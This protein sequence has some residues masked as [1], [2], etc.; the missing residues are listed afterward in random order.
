MAFE[1]F[2]AGREKTS[3][4]F[5]EWKEQLLAAPW[6]EDVRWRVGQVIYVF[7]RFCKR[8]H[9]PASVESA[10]AFV[11]SEA[12]QRDPWIRPAL[13]WLCT[14]G[15]VVDKAWLAG[16]RRDGT[17]GTDAA[18]GTDSAG[19][20]RV[21]NG[22]G[23]GGSGGRGVRPMEEL[24]GGAWESARPVVPAR[25]E[26]GVMGAGDGTDGADN[27]GAGTAG[28]ARGGEK[29]RVGAAGAED[30]TDSRGAG[31]G[32]A[33]GGRRDGIVR[34][35][36][37]GMGNGTKGTDG[38]YGTDSGGAG[39]A[40]EARG[41]VGGA[42]A[43][44]KNGTHETE[45]TDGTDRGEA[46]VMRGG[47]DGQDGTDSE[48]REGAVAGAEGAGG[49]RSSTPSR[50]AE[51]LGGPDWERALVTAL[52]RKGMLW[53]TEQTYR[54]WARRFAEFIRPRSPFAAGGEEVADFLTAMAVEFRA[55]PATQRQA[56]NA[57]VF[58][59]QEGL[60]REV[61]ELDFRRSAARKRVPTVL[62]RA[63]CT[64][65]FEAITGSNR[66]MAETMYGAGLRLMELL[67]LRVHHLDFERRQLKVYSGKGDKD[68][69]TILP[70]SVIPRL[71]EQ[72]AQAKAWFEADRAAGLPGVWV[73]EGLERKWPQ[74]GTD[75]Q[76]QWVFPSRELAADPASGVKRRHHVLD[77]TF[78]N[79]VRAAAVKAQIDKR[80][81][82]H[83]LRHSF[84]THLLEAGT[85]I[86]TVQDL[87]GHESV[88]TTQIY[89]HVMQKPGLGVRSPLDMG[90]VES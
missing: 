72:L 37:M 78:Q 7:F 28:V 88:E 90:R 55:S 71:K 21:G 53:R 57:L 17:H 38:I 79:A 40:G 86:R 29:R 25:A 52:R 82:P 66:L 75:W 26:R 11:E 59:L 73:P 35:G 67:R 44:G 6:P 15:R 63:E 48:G 70:D 10:K 45:G 58:F 41:R 50:G 68:R 20:R 61:G 36:G 80:V 60:R 5:P 14:G 89:T 13:R 19:G 2:N 34:G 65:L 16:N 74:A 81:T 84:A 39:A 33:R 76:W 24:E 51:D 8:Y 31:A 3:K 1:G 64:R 49:W 85:D 87:L 69:L 62:S 56:L 30:G 77:G 22:R 47:G 32:G 12:G 9:T 54:M 23:A 4:L 18:D 43:D 46:G 83:V 27:A 42:G